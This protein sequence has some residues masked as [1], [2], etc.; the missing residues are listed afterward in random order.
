MIKTIKIGIDLGRTIVDRENNNKPFP[1]CFDIIL[2]LSRTY[3][4]DNLFIVSR[5]NSEQKERAG[6]W[7]IDNNFYEQT[8]FLPQNVYFCFERRDKAIFAKGLGLSIFIDDRPGC[9]IPMDEDMDKILFNPYKPDVEKFER[10]IKENHLNIKSNWS[11]I[12]EYLI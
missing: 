7:L 9:L 10:E 4:P 6:K 12:R 11:E 2:G 5:V 8:E 1:R 3:G